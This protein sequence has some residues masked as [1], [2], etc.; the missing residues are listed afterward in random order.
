MLRKRISAWQNAVEVLDALSPLKVLT[1]GYS[2]TFDQERILTSVSEIETG[3]Q[4]TTRLKDGVI[5][6]TVTSVTPETA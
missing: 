3:R 1:R 4:I 2:I 6:S 5:T